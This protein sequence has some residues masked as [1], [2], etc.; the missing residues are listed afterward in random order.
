MTG[1]ML[2]GRLVSVNGEPVDDMEEAALNQIR[3]SKTKEFVMSN[4]AQIGMHQNM[5]IA[6]IPLMMW[7]KPDQT[8]SGTFLG[9]SVIFEVDMTQACHT[10]FCANFYKSVSNIEVVLGPNIVKGN[11]PK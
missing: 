2:I 4:P 1:E 5:Q 6:T 9:E 3:L 7:V 8:P 11:F 10:D